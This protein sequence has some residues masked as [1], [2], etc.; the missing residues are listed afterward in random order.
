[1]VHLESTWMSPWQ[2]DPV[3]YYYNV[4][5]IDREISRMREGH[6]H[7]GRAGFF[8]Y[9]PSLHSPQLAPPGNTP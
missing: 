8:I 3:H 6:Y 5:D 9:I 7:E 1:M 4:Y 2:K